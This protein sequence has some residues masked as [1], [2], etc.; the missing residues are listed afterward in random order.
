MSNFNQIVKISEMKKSD[1]TFLHELWH[2][3]KV[4]RYADEFPYFRVWSKSDDPDNGSHWEQV[5]PGSEHSF[6][7]TGNQLKW[8][9]VLTTTNSSKTP[10]ISSLSIS[11][12]TVTE[13]EEEV[14]P[15][16]W[17]GVGIG[18]A[19]VLIGVTVLYF[20]YYKKE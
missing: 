6:T 7:N 8:K 12:E 5:T 3:P 20:K 17:A 19:V 15:W 2:T 13:K 4:V 18:V 9:A 16:L 10:T 11:Y 14:F 1:L